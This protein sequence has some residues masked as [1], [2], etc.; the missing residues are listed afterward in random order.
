MLT[1]PPRIRSNPAPRG[2]VVRPA[3]IRALLPASI[4]GPAPG[5][6]VWVGPPLFWRGPRFRDASEDVTLFP[7]VP[8]RVLP[9]VLSM[10]LKL[11]LTVPMLEMFGAAGLVLPAT[12]V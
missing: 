10:A 4:S 11:T 7:L 12:I 1:V 9:A 6:M 3:G 5:T 2:S 8:D